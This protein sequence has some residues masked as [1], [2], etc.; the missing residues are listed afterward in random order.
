MLWTVDPG[1]PQTLHEQIAGNV[2]RAI[3]EGAL[4]AGER[5]PSAQ[6]LAGVLQVNANTVL[7]AYR[8]LRDEELLE[9]RRGRGVRVRRGA[10]GRASIND[11]A[12]Q[13]LEAGRRHG[14]DAREL[15]E[16]LITLERKQS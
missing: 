11:H 1:R 2:R 15:G 9:F 16:L 13:L 8:R 7:V 10:T 5:L 4:E 3:A 6:E 14:Y 12:H